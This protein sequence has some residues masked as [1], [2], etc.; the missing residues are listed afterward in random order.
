LFDYKLNPTA[1]NRVRVHVTGSHG[2]ISNLRYKTSTKKPISPDKKAVVKKAKKPAVKKVAVKKLV[3][4]KAVKKIVKKAAVKKVLAKKAAPKKPVKKTIKT[5]AKLKRLMGRPSEIDSN[6][7][8]E[9][10]E[11]LIHFGSLR[12]VCM[13]DDMPD[14]SSVFHWIAKAKETGAKQIY[15][16]FLDQYEMAKEM[17]VI[18][19]AGREIFDEY[20]DPA[21]YEDV[22]VVKDT[23]AIDLRPIENIRFASGADWR[24]PIGTSPFLIDEIPMT[25]GEVKLMATSDNK[26]KIPWFPLTDSQL[27]AGRTTDYNSV[28]NAREGNREDS[29]DQTYLC[30]VTLTW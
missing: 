28:R 25:I 19:E 13:A 3:P 30:A 11:R 8:T 24:D 1:T 23:P 18:D 5:R 2:R 14:K 10:C 12:K 20:G 26:T 4:K 27:L 15:I 6:V 22:T 16:D 21:F 7:C 9:L 29:K 17:A